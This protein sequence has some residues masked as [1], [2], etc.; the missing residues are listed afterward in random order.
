MRGKCEKGRGA[1]GGAKY[2]VDFREIIIKQQ[3]DAIISSSRIMGTTYVSVVLFKQ[4]KGYIQIKFGNEVNL[5]KV[6]SKRSIVPVKVII[7][8]VSH[9]LFLDPRKEKYVGLNRRDT[10]QLDI[11][12]LDQPFIHE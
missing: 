10:S 4:K 1:R 5:W 9:Q 12:Q 8:A 11:L 2:E 3:R 6:I 7:N